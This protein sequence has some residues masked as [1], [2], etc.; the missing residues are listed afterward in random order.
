MVKRLLIVFTIIGF[1]ALPAIAAGRDFINWNKLHNPILSY[2]YWSIKDCAMAYRKGTFYIFFSAF[3]KDHGR[4]R[5]HVVEVRTRDFKTY[6]RPIFDFDGVA[7]GWIGMCSPDVQ[8]IGNEYEVSFN[9][10]GDKHGKPD[11]LFYMTSPD[12]V[13]WSPCH[14]LAPNLTAGKRAIDAALAHASGVYYL[15][16]KQSIKHKRARIAFARSLRGPWA[17]VRSGYPHL[18]V[19]N[20][21]E[22]GLIHE[23]F[24]FIHFNGKW[25]LLTS[26]YPHGHHEYL[27]TLLSDRNW[28]DWGDGLQLKI[29]PQSFNKLVQA[30]A[31]AM[32]DWRKRDG[33]FYMIYAGRNEKRTYLGRGWNRL[34][35]ARSNDLIHWIPAGATH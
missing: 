26:D 2:P 15:A 14:P 20:G 27:Y 1:T 30:D 3:Y 11:Q 8:W 34:G 28:L 5:S 24:E 17:F 25:H 33:Y 9:S 4:V 35:L 22:N 31:A 12:L 16:W 23:N 7:E 13:H 6:S 19:P 18:T 21:R 10:W 29:P 32:Y